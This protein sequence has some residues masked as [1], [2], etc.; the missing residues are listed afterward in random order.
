LLDLHIYQRL[1]AQINPVSE[2]CSGEPSFDLSYNTLS[3]ASLEFSVIFS[4]LAKAAG[5]ADTTGYTDTQGMFTIHLPENVLPNTYT[6]EVTIDNH[7]CE[8]VTLPITIP[9]LYS[10]QIIIQ[11]WND[12]LAVSKSIADSYQG[13]YQY[14]WY[15][16]GTPIEGE[17]GT[18]YYNPNGLQMD[19][20]YQVELT[21]H[22]DSTVI[23]SCPYMPELHPDTQTLIVQ[24]TALTPSESMQ[25]T[26]PDAGEMHIICNTGYSM[27]KIHMQAGDNTVAA[28]AT[29]GLYFIH[30]TTQDGQQYVQKI[31]VY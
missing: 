15:F 4:E 8:M 29:S 19:G 23:I 18:Y 11:R 20:F 12:L 26:A 25:I 21:R 24:P 27:G 2:I 17:T 1:D 6:A 22:Q 5:F 3:D 30:L 13:F 7:G 10:S 14:Q 28:P 16:N 9:V 31:I